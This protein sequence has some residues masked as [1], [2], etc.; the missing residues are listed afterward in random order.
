MTSEA[1]YYI[2][3]PGNN[4]ANDEDDNWW[5][6]RDG[7]SWIHQSSIVAGLPESEHPGKFTRAHVQLF[8]KHQPAIEGVSDDG[9]IIKSSQSQ[10]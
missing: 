3:L 8:Q 1:K 6:K 2:T 9:E 4:A 5:L 10:P 7:K